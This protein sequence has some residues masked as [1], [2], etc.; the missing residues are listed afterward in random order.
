MSEVDKMKNKNQRLLRWG[1]MLHVY[2]QEISIS[3]AKTLSLQTAS[4]E[5]GLV[6]RKFYKLSLRGM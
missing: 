1:L 4:P 2:K 3:K 5:L 6:A